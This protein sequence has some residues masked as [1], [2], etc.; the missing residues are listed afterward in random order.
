MHPAIRTVILPFA[1][2]GAMLAV[3]A[4]VAQDVPKAA[5]VAGAAPMPM[6][7]LA[8][9]TTYVFVAADA[10]REAVERFKKT[11]LHAFTQTEPMRKVLGEDGGAEDAM[12]K[13]LKELELPEDA[14]SWPEAVGAVLFTVHDEELDAEASHLLVYADWGTHADGMAKVIDQ[15]IAES[16]RKDGVTV[17]K[18]DLAGREM[19]VLKLREAADVAKRNGRAGAMGVQMDMSFAQRA[20]KLYYV[21]DGSRFFLSTDAGGIQ[22]ALASVDGKRKAALADRADF[23]GAM[24]QMGDADLAIALLTGPMQKSIAGEGAGML[25]LLQPVLQPIFGDVQAWTIG[26][27]AATERGQIEVTSGIFVPGQKTGLWALM[28]PA[29]PVEAPPPMIGPDVIGFGRINMQFKEVMNLVNTVAANLPEMEAQQLDA[30]LVNFGPVLSKGF[31]ALGPNVW[32]YETV[33]QPLT[34]ESRVTAVVTNCTN[35]KAVVPMITQ[36][37]GT[38]GLEPRDVDGNTIFS[39]DFMPIAVGVSNGYLA[40]GDGKLVEQAMRS[41]G[42]KDLPTIRD[43][44]NWKAAS[45]AV[46]SGDLVSWGFVDLVGRWEYE[47]AMLAEYG[48]DDSKLD[49][50]V[51]RADDGSVAGRI[52]YKLPANANDTLKGIDGALLG[53]HVGPFVWSMKSVDDGFVTRAWVMSPLGGEPKPAK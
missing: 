40:S 52:G 4:A 10:A 47:R 28:G 18:D 31:E 19:Q 48:K 24:Q 22:D 41:M 27:S 32:T 16:V 23:K 25:S 37:G 21:R 44:A 36:F 33:R 17:S 1:L 14:L 39:A 7:A 38:M 13:R 42:Q 50:L 26:V 20:E 46:G 3:P 8:P 53:K 6:R 15:V 30:Y 11:P 51:G 43:N 12:K 34:P 5:I 9:D 35:P 29:K 49:N 2:A 45:S